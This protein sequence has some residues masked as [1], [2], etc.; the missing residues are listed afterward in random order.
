MEWAIREWNILVACLLLILPVTLLCLLAYVLYWVKSL[1]GAYRDFAS[2]DTHGSV[3][4][5]MAIFLQIFVMVGAIFG[6][7]G[8]SMANAQRRERVTNGQPTPT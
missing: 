4:T 2:V 5:L 8:T 1:S 3:I 6:L 7:L